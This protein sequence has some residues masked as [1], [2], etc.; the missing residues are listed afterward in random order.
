[1]MSRQDGAIQQGRHLLTR[2]RNCFV[3]SS[4]NLIYLHLACH[5]AKCLWKE[6]L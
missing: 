3:L 1:M 6:F 5:E 2:H 4:E